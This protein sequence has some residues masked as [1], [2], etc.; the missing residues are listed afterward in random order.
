VCKPNLPGQ[1]LAVNPLRQNRVSHQFASVQRPQFGLPGQRTYDHRGRRLTIL[2]PTVTSLAVWHSHWSNLT[3][4]NRDS[5]LC[6]MR[7]STSARTSIVFV[8]PSLSETVRSPRQTTSSVKRHEM[9][10]HDG[11][12]TSEILST[13]TTR[14][15]ADHLQIASSWQVRPSP[16]QS[17]AAVQLLVGFSRGGLQ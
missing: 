4:N 11:Y 14:N 10:T 17:E 9:G 6:V 3:E 5:R 12:Y 1:A 16:R 7:G 8:V 13:A 15:S 2:T